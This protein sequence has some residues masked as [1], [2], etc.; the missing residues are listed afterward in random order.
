MNNDFLFHKIVVE[1]ENW[2]KKEN[3]KEVIEKILID[4]SKKFNEKD[5]LNK[6]MKRKVLPNLNIRLNKKL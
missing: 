2:N 5:N 4:S 1:N 6:K 3:S